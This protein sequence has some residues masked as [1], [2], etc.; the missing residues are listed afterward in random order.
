MDGINE[1][2]ESILPNRLIMTFKV[3][4]FNVPKLKER[5][6]DLVVQKIFLPQIIIIDGLVFNEK[7][8]ETLTD[9]RTM[10]QKHAL[11]LW[12][13]V[14]APRGRELPLNEM[15]ECLLPVS[16]LFDVLFRLEPAGEDVRVAPLSGT[17]ALA[18]PL[19][20]DPATL[21]I[22]NQAGG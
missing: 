12:F 5:L 7:A 2:W 3:E 11:R 18:K 9:L 4:G 15:P 19:F 10:A 13:T 22:R 20:L 17:P 6:Y 1:T 21:L 14:H 8:R 16:D